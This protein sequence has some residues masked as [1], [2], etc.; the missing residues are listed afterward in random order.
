MKVQYLIIKD[1]K[2]SLPSWNAPDFFLN[3]WI[4]TKKSIYKPM[5]ELG[6]Q[7]PP[8]NTPRTRRYYNIFQGLVCLSV[9]CSVVQT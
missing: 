8:L 9:K 1:I 6:D 7:T 3:P 4:D 2:W 5:V